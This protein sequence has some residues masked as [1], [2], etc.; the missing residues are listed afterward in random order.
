M[1]SILEDTGDAVAMPQ[2]P[3]RLVSRIFRD[4]RNNLGLFWKVML[5]LIIINFLFYLGI[6][7]FA[8]LMSPEGQWTISTDSRLTAYT[9]S[10]ESVQPVGVVWGTHLGVSSF[11]IS[12]LWLAMCPLIFVIVQRRNGIDTTFRAVWQQTF[13][14]TV[15]ILG[16][17]FFIGM[18]F[19]GVPIVFGFLTFAF[20]FQELVQSNAPTLVF[21]FLCIIAAWFVLSAYFTVRWSLY[22]QAIMIENLSAIG[23]L[24]RSNELVRGRT[25]WKFLGIY[26]L[27]ALAFTALTSLLLGLTMA[28]LSFAAPEFIPMRE[29]LLPGRFISLL[30]FGYA[31][32]TLENA[33]TFWT[34]GVIFGVY[35]LICAVFAPVWASLTTQLYMER[36]DEH[37]QQVSA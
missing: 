20:F 17:A 10:S 35:T 33:P 26:L 23:A 36:A 34:V 24:R 5:P 30:F 3:P 19:F 37:A 18:L 25:W 7:P 1:Q 15:P 28:L 31:K 9:S 6:F 11:H 29:A 4:Y 16:T 13:R 14:K 21:V 22:N 32:M 8:K 27:L 12:F 2:Q